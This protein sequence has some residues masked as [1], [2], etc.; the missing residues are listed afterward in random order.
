MNTWTDWVM[1]T[2]VNAM[3]GTSLGLS[4]KAVNRCLASIWIRW[5][6]DLRGEG[7]FYQGDPVEADYL[8]IIF[9]N[10][11]HYG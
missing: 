1:L 8:W 5:T 7:A 11:H 6:T 2:G 10:S 3:L 9:R 4:F